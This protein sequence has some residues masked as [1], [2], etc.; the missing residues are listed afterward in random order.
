[1]LHI[2]VA[3]ARAENDPAAI[4]ADGDE[5]SRHDIVVVVFVALHD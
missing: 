4:G 1:M 2:P 5:M 3:L